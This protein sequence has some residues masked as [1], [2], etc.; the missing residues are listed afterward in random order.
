[1]CHRCVEYRIRTNAA[2]YLPR[3]KDALLWALR[4]ITNARNA[5]CGKAIAI[6]MSYIHVHDAP[7]HS[8]NA[9]RI[10]MQNIDA[11]G[12]CTTMVFTPMS[13]VSHTMLRE[14][15]LK[16][17]KTLVSQDVR[18]SEPLIGGL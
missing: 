11:H 8:A 17:C 18:I 1:M 6:P 15:K 14:D 13:N 10:G 3:V 12:R 16:T 9:R 4:C 7:C 2:A 5:P